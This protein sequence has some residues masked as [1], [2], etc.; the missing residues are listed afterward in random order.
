MKGIN[1]EAY[2]LGPKGENFNFYKDL[3][4]KVIESHISWRKAYHAHEHF[5]FITEQDRISSDYIEAQRKIEGY[6]H[7][8]IKRLEIESQPFFSPR[9]IGH[10]NWE[11]MIAPLI[12]YF[13]AALFNPNNV[14]LT[15]SPSTSLL[16]L[17]V[18]KD[19]LK[20]MGMDEERGWGHI[21]AGGTIAN[22]EALWIAR[23]MKY[24]PIA[25]KKTAKRFRLDHPICTIKEQELIKKYDPSEILDL[26]EEIF[27]EIINKKK[28][29][30]EEDKKNVFRDIENVFEKM[31]LQE[32]GMKDIDVGVIYMPQTKHYSL[33]KTADLIGV[34]RESIRYVPVDEK[35]RMNIGELEEMLKNESRPILAVVA[36][37]GTTEES[38]VDNVSKLIEIRE[39]LHQQ[40][41]GFHLHVD[42]AYGGYARSIFLDENGQFF[43]DVDS[44]KEKLDELKIIGKEKN[45]PDKEIFESFKALS[46]ADTITIDPHKLGYIPYPAGGIVLKDKRMREAIQVFAPYVFGRPE[47][48]EPDQLIG[49]YILEGSKPGAS[50]AAVW[51]AH[52][53][54]PLNI[55]GYGKL[56]GETIDGAL[57][58]YEALEKAPLFDVDDTLKIKVWPLLR[59]DINIINYV[60]NF[61][62]N[63]N[64]EKLNNLTS[65]FAKELIGEKPKGHKGLLEKAYLVS[66]TE[67]TQDEYGES[68]ISFLK[69][70]GINTSEWGRVKTLKVI[71]SVIMSPYL[72]PDYVE[73]SYADDFIEFLK[74][75]IKQNKEKIVEIWKK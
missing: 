52:R 26:K 19:F 67:F 71:R 33:K 13:A 39:K 46:E 64:L 27:N 17:E 44:L 53:I 73:K 7:N 20:L 45:W 74:K 75:E 40:G 18:G 31:T 72:T 43:K 62:N 68:V 24:I 14:A 15:G 58:L 9:Y 3:L 61:E 42:A 34:G 51:L 56:I 16:E 37:V 69:K 6:I 5:E 29:I 10:M 30:S 47:K 60:F 35:F 55:T 66:S 41:K 54:M 70:I 1:F 12:A 22:I 49:A 48:G 36:V 11:V 32:K 25:L 21:C 57:R 4:E 23:N 63:T 65:F 28:P 59:P 8:I 2:F 38:A 50:A